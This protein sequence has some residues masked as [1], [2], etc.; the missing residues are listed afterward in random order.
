MLFIDADVDENGALRVVR[1]EQGYEQQERAVRERTR[2]SARAE[3]RCA[4]SPL[5]AGHTAAYEPLGVV[6]GM[7]YMRTDRDAPN[8]KSSRCRS[9]SRTSPTGRRSSAE[10]KNAI[11][12]TRLIAGKLA[13][14]A[15]VDV[16]S[17]VTL[18]NLDGTA[19]GAITP[20]GLGTINGPI[21]RT[22]ARTCSIVHVAAESDD[23]V[24]IST[25]RPA[26][27]RRSSRRN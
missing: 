18:Y 15:L 22:I 4:G 10:S 24:P 8:G 27:A 13:V 11:E 14:N 5:Y 9:T 25:R 26:R 16:A 21:G 1:H 19:A 2:R 17:E 6:G 20:P 23:R 12:S 7:L 3:G